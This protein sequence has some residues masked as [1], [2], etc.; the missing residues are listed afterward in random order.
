M[1]KFKKI[2]IFTILFFS[3]ANI[4]HAELPYYLDFKYILN[5]SDAGKKAQIELKKKLD[6][7]LKSITDREKK[8]QNEEK[9]IIEQKKIVS[10][11]EYKKKVTE[12][13]TKVLNLQKDRNKL[14]ETVAKQRKNARNILLKNLNPII[15]DYMIE[16]KIRYV[17]DKKSLILADENLDITKP[18]MSLLNKKL[19]SIKIN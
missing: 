6:T 4:S 18:I 7:G 13:R 3:T 2:L 10:P 16:K 1:S 14:L 11:D 9:K 17:M 5:E 15:K 12:L 8:L 19:K